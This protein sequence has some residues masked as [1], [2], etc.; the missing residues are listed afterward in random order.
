MVMPGENARIEVSL[1]RPIALESGSQFAIREG[2][3]TVGRGAVSEV[4]E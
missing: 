1:E 3:K 4:M 2:G